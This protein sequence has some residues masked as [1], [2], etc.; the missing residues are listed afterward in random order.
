MREGFAMI[1]ILDMFKIV[2]SWCL[3]ILALVALCLGCELHGRHAVKVEWAAATQEANRKSEEKLAAA[4]KRATTAESTMK[5]KI[6]EAND[7]RDKKIAIVNRKLATA[8]DELR[9]R[10]ARR[11]DAD[12]EGAGT[13]G[14]CA[15]ASGAELSKPDAGFLEREAA[16]ADRYVIELNACNARSIGVATAINSLAP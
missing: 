10:P 16:R 5:A 15:G 3:W 1:A 4:T 2:P 14:Q 9:T 7:E 8:L 13:T 6:K 12:S 11:A